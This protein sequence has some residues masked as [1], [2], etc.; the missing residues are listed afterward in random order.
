MPSYG[1]PLLSSA[2]PYHSYPVGPQQMHYAGQPGGMMVPGMMGSLSM[3]MQAPPPQY[4]PPQHPG[5]FMQGLPQYYVQSRHSMI[6]VQQSQRPYPGYPQ[7]VPPGPTQYLAYPPQ[8]IQLAP[9]HATAHMRGSPT[10]PHS[11][12]SPMPLGGGPDPRTG[13]PASP[14]PAHAHTFYLFF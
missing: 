6:M 9:M 13:L 1:S 7:M 3:G 14:D 8:G 10:V 2:A 12:S 5:M 11:P 4:A